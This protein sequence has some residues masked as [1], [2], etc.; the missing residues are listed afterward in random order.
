MEKHLFR[1]ATV[2]SWLKGLLDETN[3][4]Q[5]RLSDLTGHSI[6]TINRIIHGKGKRTSPSTA[7][8]ILRALFPYDVE[9]QAKE[10]TIFKTLNN[11]SNK[12]K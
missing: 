3:I 6:A 4:T 12:N 8:N 9:R 2:G 11:N 1:E 5:T 10:F 7:T